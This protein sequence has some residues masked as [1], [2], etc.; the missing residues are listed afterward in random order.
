MDVVGTHIQEKLV[1]FFAVS[2]FWLCAK[3]ILAEIVSCDGYEK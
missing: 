2:Q 3:H 1:E